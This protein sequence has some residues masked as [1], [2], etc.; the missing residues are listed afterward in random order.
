VDGNALKQSG[1][2]FQIQTEVYTGPL[3]LLI[4]LIERRKFLVND[5]SLAS[6]TDDYMK[7]VAALEE[8]PIRDIADFI[9]LAATLL[10]LKSKSLLPVL[11]LTESEEESVDQL[12]VRLRFYQIFRN[13]GKTLSSVF[14]LH[15]AYERPYVP[16]R[17]PRFTPDRFTTQSAIRE[18][19]GTVIQNLPKKVEKP[20]VQVRKV[21][22]LE[23]MIENLRSRI[24]RQLSF[25]FKDFTGDIKER[26]TVI[27]GFL[28]ILE[29]VKQEMILVKQ[30]AHFEEISIERNTAT[31][32]SYN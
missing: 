3:D 5:I 12:E 4:E 22:S 20:Q 14:G 7:Y 15:R 17:T 11:E 29:M 13:A 10:L 25:T 21:I 19:I 27:V 26:G 1:D 31:P 24:E 16:D 9:V 6:V 18:A 30:T 28:A 23:H 2:Q 8:R 32:P